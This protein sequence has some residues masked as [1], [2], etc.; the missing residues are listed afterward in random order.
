MLGVILKEW[1]PY[2]GRNSNVRDLHG[3]IRKRHPWGVVGLS[4]EEGE[5]LIERQESEVKDSSFVHFGASLCM[6]RY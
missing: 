1:D 2:L 3:Q 5:A 4:V 6:D